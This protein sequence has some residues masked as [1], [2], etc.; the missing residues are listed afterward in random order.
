MVI[1]DDLHIGETRGYRV[2][3]STRLA[4]DSDR[5]FFL[6]VILLF[7]QGDYPAQAKC[8]GMTHAGRYCCHWCLFQVFFFSLPSLIMILTYEYYYNRY[9]L[10]II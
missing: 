8:S 1:A 3:D 7:V 2:Y 5:I 9:F 6:K 10:D 4:G